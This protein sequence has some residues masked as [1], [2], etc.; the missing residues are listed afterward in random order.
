[1]VP[2]LPEEPGPAH[3]IQEGNPVLLP[4]LLPQIREVSSHG[5][6]GIQ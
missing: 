6:H 1:M 2:H 4:F 5:N 3:L